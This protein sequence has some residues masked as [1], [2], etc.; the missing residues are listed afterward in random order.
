[1]QC[2]LQNYGIFAYQYNQCFYLKPQNCQSYFL[3]E[4]HT[5]INEF[6]NKFDNQCFPICNNGIIQEEEQCDD[7]NL[8][9]FDGCFQCSSSC[10]LECLDCQNSFCFQCL[11][12]WNLIDFLCVQ[13][14]GDGIIALS[15]QEQCDDQNQEQ[16]DGCYECKFE[17]QY[18]CIFCNGNL[19]CAICKEYFE[20]KDNLCIPICGDGYI[21]EGLEICDD[22]NDIKYDGCYDCEYSCQE[23]CQICDHQNCLDNCDYGYYQVD[24]E[25]NSICGDSIVALNEQC[26]DANDDAYDGCYLCVF[27]CPQNCLHCHDQQ[28]FQCDHG[29][30]L[31]NNNCQDI[32]GNGFKSDQVQCDDGNL[33]SQDG[34][35]ETCEIELNW[36]CI[37]VK[38]KNTSCFLI[39]PPHFNLILLNQTFDVQFVQIQ[40]TDQIKLLDSSQNLTQNL[41]ASLIDINPLH[42]TIANTFIIEPNNQSVH[43]IIYFLRI[44]ILEQQTSE[45]FLQVQLNTLLVDRNGFQVDNDICKIHINN[46]LVLTETQRM[47]SHKISSYN[48]L[49]LIALGVSSM[50]ILISGNPAECFEVLDTIQYQSNLKFININFPEN[51]II[52]FQSSEVVSIFP[53]LEKF[54]IVDL[55]QDIIGQQQSAYGQFLKYN[56][57]SDLI[58]NL[59]GLIT[60]LG[61]ITLLL[62][63]SFCYLN[64]I[65][66]SFFT[67]IC[68]FINR[69]H[70]I[71]LL[72]QFG[73][74]I[75]KLNEVSLG[76]LS[77]LSRQGAI[78]ILQA[79]SWDLIFKSLLFLF[80]KKEISY[81]NTAQSILAVSILIS[82]A[83]LMSSFFSQSLSRLKQK[84]ISFGHESLIIAK[85]F[86]ILIILISSQNNSIIQC[87]MIACVNTM[88]IT[89]IILSKMTKNKIDLITILVFE[90][91][92]VI[93][94]LLSLS[95]DPIIATHLN[96]ETQII[97]G[98]LLIG[99]LSLGLAAPLVKYAFQIKIKLAKFILKFK[100]KR[101]K[102]KLKQKRSTQIFY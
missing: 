10:Q 60:Q 86:L 49:I 82:I 76:L 38:S 23:N 67:Q 87:V 8:I 37:Q 66:Y 30:K 75:N 45:I 91:P 79:N 55:Y 9:Q 6:E 96:N 47:I 12:G 85:K 61:L 58:T 46:P 29:F 81:R 17:C 97:I 65:F 62:I 27:S 102:E 16:G 93:F 72:S 50:I 21:I 57:N 1:M 5:C 89:T 90:I 100:Q 80:S 34:C 25:C 43:N 11:Q 22:G 99:L 63:L 54:L 92:I 88:Y 42:Y 56:I 77:M 26:D 83:I 53:I 31:I 70:Q 33:L 14:C 101:L 94:T 36:T 2:Q 19:E 74:L 13:E 4:C 98:F 15:S 44:Q 40:F 32:C 84:K 48:M 3:N 52:Y 73:Y 78:Y 69:N 35:S 28:C 39:T 64:F 7:Q 68:L 71:L 51:L 59:I 24:F 20:I 95:F 18:N 41:K